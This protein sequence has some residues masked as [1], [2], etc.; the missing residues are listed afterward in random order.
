MRNINKDY[1]ENGEYDYLDR[2]DYNSAQKIRDKNYQRLKYLENSYK[3]QMNDN[4][5]L[6]PY[7]SLKNYDVNL[8]SLIGQE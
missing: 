1:K 4:N 3:K 8:Y 7:K 2:I 5:K 6:N